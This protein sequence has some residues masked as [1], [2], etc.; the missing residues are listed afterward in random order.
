MRRPTLYTGIHKPHFSAGLN[1]AMISLNVLESR[2]GDFCANRWI[3]D[4]GAFTRITSG[5]GHMPADKYARQIRRWARCGLLEAAVCQDWMCEPFVTDLTG[6]TVPEHQARTTASYLTL[7]DLVADTYIMPV[8]QGFEADDYKAHTDALSQHL[9]NGAWVGVGSIC[10]RNARPDSISAIL[11]AILSV[12]PDLLLHGFGVKT[13]AL[14]RA[15]IMERFH[16][17]DSMAWSAAGRRM[18]PSRANSLS[19]AIAWT[20]KVNAIQP[21]PSQMSF[22]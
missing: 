1:H 5:R 9:P 11:T 21:L 20:A 2:V 19:W 15:D 12:R 18:N 8:I 14:R 10:K 7:R 17:V 4:S 6:L 13:T 22:V 3:L 16:S